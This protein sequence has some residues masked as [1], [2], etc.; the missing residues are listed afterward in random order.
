MRSRA[1]TVVAASPANVPPATVQSGHAAKWTSATLA[2]MAPSGKANI[3]SAARRSRRAEVETSTSEPS[4]SVVPVGMASCADPSP[5]P[6]RPWQPAQAS[7]SNSTTCPRH[8]GVR[9]TP[10]RRMASPGRRRAGFAALSRKKRRRLLA[11]A[12]KACGRRWQRY[13]VRCQ[14]A[15][16]PL[17]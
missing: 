17:R 9:T 14:P 2:A 13:A 8:P 3:A 10:V 11:S 16:R 12:V 6:H 5:K 7:K 1:N 4:G 15:P